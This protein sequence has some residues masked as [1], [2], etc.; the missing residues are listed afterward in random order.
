MMVRASSRF[1]K[2]I[3]PREDDFPAVPTALRLAASDASNWQ[4]EVLAFLNGLKASRP[5]GRLE[6][7]RLPLPLGQIRQ[8]R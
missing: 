4:A 1:A 3:V 8:G 7:G 5:A 6:S 2:Q